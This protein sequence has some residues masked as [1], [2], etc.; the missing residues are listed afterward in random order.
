VVHPTSSLRRSRASRVLESN[1]SSEASTKTG[2]R[3][4]HGPPPPARAEAHRGLDR[5]LAVVPRRR[6]GLDDGPAVLATGAKLGCSSRVPGTITVA[7][8]SVGHTRGV[9]PMRRITLSMASKWHP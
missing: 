5:A 3:G 6:P 1:R 2:D 4:G 8:R 7:R 9:L